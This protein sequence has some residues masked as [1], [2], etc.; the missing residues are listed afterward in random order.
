MFSAQ[1]LTGAA[2][3]DVVADTLVKY[4]QTQ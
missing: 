3:G 2:R 1:P 4:V